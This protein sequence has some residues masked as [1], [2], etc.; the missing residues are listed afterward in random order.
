MFIYIELKTANHIAT[1]FKGHKR[2]CRWK[3][4]M[5]AKCNLIVERQKVMAAQVALRRQQAREECEA[6]D[7][8]K[9]IN[10]DKLVKLLQERDGLTYTAALQFVA[11][12]KFA[13]ASANLERETQ[14]SSSS[15]STN[16][17]NNSGNNNN[18]NQF[19]ANCTTVNRETVDKSSCCRQQTSTTK[20]HQVKGEFCSK[21]S[22]ILL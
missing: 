1:Q 3:D 20:E 14:I 12:N 17:N 8:S 22:L 6:R 11:T 10:V 13:P 7:L 2:N 16:N 18:N 15:S 21:K 5:C 19:V 4:C 9:Q